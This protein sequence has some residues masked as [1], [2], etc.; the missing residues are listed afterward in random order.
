[1][2]VLT[3][4]QAKDKFGVLMDTALREPVTITKHNRPAVVVISSERYTELEALEDRLWIAKAEEA[5]KEGFLSVKESEAFI[6][7]IL[8]AEA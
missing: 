4:K 2:V 1:M 3:S 7:E 6:Q 5:E 8:N